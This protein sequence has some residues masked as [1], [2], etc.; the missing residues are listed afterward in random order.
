MA[1]K[2]L[3]FDAY[4]KTLFLL[5]NGTISPQEALQD[6]DNHRA[7]CDTQ[8]IKPSLYLNNNNDVVYNDEKAKPF[9]FKAPGIDVLTT[10]Y[11]AGKEHPLKFKPYTTVYEGER[12]QEPDKSTVTVKKE[13][14][15]WCWG[16]DKEV[17][18]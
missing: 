3:P 6:I 4:V 7:Y 12:G 5:S 16:R 11:E 2:E 8:G 13:V 14:L 10:Y 15:V 1:T 9:E 18:H 17:L